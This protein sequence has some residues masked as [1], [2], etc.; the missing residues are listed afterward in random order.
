MF[1]GVPRPSSQAVSGPEGG[2]EPRDAWRRK[3]DHSG[4]EDLR[5][6]RCGPCL[7]WGLLSLT[8]RRKERPR[9]VQ[10]LAGL[11]LPRSCVS[12][13]TW[14]R[15]CSGRAEEGWGGHQMLPGREASA[16]G[17]SPRAQGGSWE[18]AGILT[19][20]APTLAT[21][22]RVSLTRDR[23]TEGLPWGSSGQNVQE[24]RKQPATWALGLQGCE[25]RAL[26][27]ENA[28]G[29]QRWAGERQSEPGWP[30]RW[31]PAYF[32]LSFTGFSG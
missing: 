28:G 19:T 17:K 18:L 15:H 1:T 30:L 29:L 3:Q 10:G 31:R 14:E 23:A 27:W 13:R 26:P 16:V 2:S 6:K 8:F 11:G 9:Q 7:L 22:H 24:Q 21:V 32:V 4:P 20:E 5:V 12:L 25:P